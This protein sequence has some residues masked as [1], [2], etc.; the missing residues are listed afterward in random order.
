MVND[1]IKIVN[2]PHFLFP[3]DTKDLIRIGNT[4]DGSY[5]IDKNSLLDSN[6][7]I[8]IGVGW[9][10]DFEKSFLKINKVPLLAF[11]G[12]AGIISTLKKIKFRL[13]QIFIKKDFKYFLDSMYYFSYLFK[14]YF[15]FKNFRNSRLNGNYRKFVKKFVGTKHSE[16]S[17]LSILEKFDPSST[18]DKIFFQI[19]IEGGEY[20]I[21]SELLNHQNKI[22]GLVIEFHEIQEHLEEIKKFIELFSLKLVHTHINNVGGLTSNDCPKVVELTFAKCNVNKKVLSLPHSLDKPNSK[23]HLNYAAHLS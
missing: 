13:K 5:L 19:D 18:F 4:Q 20:S 14:F 21:L 11:D 22:I 17:I 15:F 16:I 1:S 8:S 9:S 2:L 12:S 7:L 6:L 23:K 10:F 3:Y